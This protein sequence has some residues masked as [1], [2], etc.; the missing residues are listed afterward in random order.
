LRT[1]RPPRT[2]KR[3]SA[4]SRGTGADMA[5]A[6]A[7]SSGGGG[8]RGGGHDAAARSLQAFVRRRLREM[9]RARAR[10]SHE[11]LASAAESS[12]ARAL[13]IRSI[14]IDR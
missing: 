1:L 3:K 10:Y 6:G 9:L 12:G 5:A 7:A 4:W 11:R 8:T 13:C 14:P 2:E